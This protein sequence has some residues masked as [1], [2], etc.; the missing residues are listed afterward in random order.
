MGFV[1][2]LKMSRRTLK[3]KPPSF[4]RRPATRGREYSDI[5]GLGVAPM[6]ISSDV[7]AAM[8]TNTSSSRPLSGLLRLN[9]DTS[10]VFN[11]SGQITQSAADTEV[12]IELPLPSVVNSDGTAVV[13]EIT[14]FECVWPSWPNATG[15]YIQYLRLYVDSAGSDSSMAFDDNLV[16]DSRLVYRVTGGAENL[17]G[18]YSKHQK[19]KLTEGGVGRIVTAP[20]VTLWFN[21]VGFTSAAT[22]YYR[23]NY[24]QKVITTAAYIGS[25]QHQKCNG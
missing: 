25:R 22:F 12:S 17:F 2:S 5:R 14:S 10:R 24:K 6:A 19:Y 13:S 18:T 3:S 21:T 4:Y 16:D 15:N 7:I 11:V 23:L 8:G 9:T 20:R 1:F